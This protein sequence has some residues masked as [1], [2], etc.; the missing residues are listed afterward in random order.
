MATRLSFENSNEI[1]VFSALTNSYCLTGK[2]VLI[3]APTL[4]VFLATMYLTV[5][6][7]FS[8]IRHRRFRKLLFRL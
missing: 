2:H 1:G 5:S 8:S 7:Y 4:S 3:A 6:L